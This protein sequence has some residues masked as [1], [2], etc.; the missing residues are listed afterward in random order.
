MDAAH[1]LGRGRL[2]PNG[3]PSSSEDVDLMRRIAARDELALRELFERHAAI[4]FAVCL[5]VLVDRHEAELVLIDIFA[6]VWRTPERFRPERGSVTGYLVVIARS[7]AVD[8][9]RAN[10][11][12]RSRPLTA[13]DS[14][15]VGHDA[16]PAAA[17]IADERRATIRA[18]LHS[19]SPE[20]REAV[21]L[22]FFTGL[23]HTAISE[24]LCK[25]IG[26]VKTHIRQGLI[27]LRDTLKE[28]QIFD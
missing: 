9:F 25:P 27:R 17:S 8:H 1:S 7:R 22:A 20:Q 12:V 24:K 18:A 3:Q 26:T 23:T 11:Q 13:N 16:H 28:F 21:E 4:C 19:L 6:E 2:I 5:R 14:S 15:I 10:K